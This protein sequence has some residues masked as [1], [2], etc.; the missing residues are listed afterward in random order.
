[1]ALVRHQAVE[2]HEVAQESQTTDNMHRTVPVSL[3]HRPRYSFRLAVC[4]QTYV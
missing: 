3:S 4:S 2:L 1:M